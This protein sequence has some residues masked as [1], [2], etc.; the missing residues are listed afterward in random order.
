MTSLIHW[1]EG[2]FLQPHH[3][4]RFQSSLN[5]SITAERNLIW[6]YP[7]GVVEAR[8]SDDDLANRRV[9]FERLRL[10]MKSG[11]IIDF[12]DHAAI[13]TLDLKQALERFRSGFVVSLGVPQWD[14]QRANVYSQSNTGE[15]RVK[16]HYLVRE[17]EFRDENTGENPRSVPLRKINASLL[18]P[19]D[20]LT[21]METIPL[22]RV[23][24][25]VGQE[26]GSCRQ[27]P[28]FA[29]PT[30]VLRG[31]PALRKMVYDLG[32]QVEASRDGLVVQI[33]QG[34][35]NMELLRGLQLEQLL[36]LRTLNHFT[37]RIPMLVE[38]ENISPFTL[39]MELHSFL[40]E[41]SALSPTQDNFK[42]GRFNHEDPLP[43]FKDL[44]GRIRSLLKGV[45]TASFMKLEFAITEDYLSL[46]LTDE[47]LSKPNEYFLGIETSSEHRV[48]T[49][50]VEDPDRFKLMPKAFVR[51]PI[52]GIK[53]KEERIPPPELPAKSTLKYYRILRSD[54]GRMWDM[55]KREKAMAVRWPGME[56]S[57]FKVTLYMTIPN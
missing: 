27:D 46:E 18:L 48:V 14:E 49:E 32:A 19:D 43:V 6:A 15:T 52:Y 22:L 1:H 57:D 20:D 39:F 30:M 35:F 12:P 34:G 54:S 24:P 36:R 41:L 28:N 42:V 2:L 8:L 16:V 5:Q 50:L 25:G 51:R 38:L 9:R 29:P 56:D 33:N 3:L 26:I 40:G 11:V 21:N 23:V 55:L 10:V 17:K 45:V 37:A 13:P 4:Q 7:Y 53:L 44:C 47:H 31:S